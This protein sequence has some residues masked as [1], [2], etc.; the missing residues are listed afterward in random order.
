MIAYPLIGFVSILIE[1]I[2]IL[3]V[4]QKRVRAY[5]LVVILTV[6]MFYLV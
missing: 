2:G 5:T 3:L 1:A 6:I 4:P